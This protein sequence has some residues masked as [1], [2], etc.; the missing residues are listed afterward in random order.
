[1]IPHVTPEMLERAIP[2]ENNMSGG[3]D[4]SCIKALG[5]R[6]EASRYRNVIAIGTAAG[7]TANRPRLYALHISNLHVLHVMLAM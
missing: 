5:G 2:G 7:C 4:S 1:M 3:I 6:A